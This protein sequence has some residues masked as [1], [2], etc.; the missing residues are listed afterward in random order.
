MALPSF[1]GGSLGRAEQ[2]NLHLAWAWS[3]CMLQR[4]A[5]VIGSII[6]AQAEPI[7]CKLDGTTGMKSCFLG[8]ED[9]QSV[10]EVDI[11]R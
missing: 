4:Q 11:Q 8:W 6:V 7:R 5:I 3:I 1:L 9:N 10:Y 2:T